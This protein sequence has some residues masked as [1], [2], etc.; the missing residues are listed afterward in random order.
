MIN[1]DASRFAR[2]SEVTPSSAANAGWRDF[3]PFTVICIAGLAVHILLIFL[4]LFIGADTLALLNVFSVAVWLAASLLSRKGKITCAALLALCEVM[5]HSTIACI[6]L[7]LGAGFQIYMWAPMVLSSTTPGVSPRFT[8]PMAVVPLLLLAALEMTLADVP[9]TFLHPEYL[10]YILLGNIFLTGTILLFTGISI[11]LENQRQ[12]QRLI[13]LANHDELTGLSNRRFGRMTLEHC[14]ELAERNKQPF[15]VAMADID[16]F[17]KLNDAFGHDAGDAVLRN[18]A[19]SFKS[20]LRKSDIVCRWGGE[21]F[22]ILISNSCLESAWHLLESL[23]ISIQDAKME[24]D[25]PLPGI[26]ISFGL[27]QFSPG[28][29][30][31]SL[32]TRADNLLYRAKAEGRNRT[33][34]ER[35]FSRETARD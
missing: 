35:D 16:Y 18:V 22:L 34:A 21:E 10:R 4:F 14:K 19:H 15:C 29:P 6:T 32:I 2:L 27:A 12:Q 25:Q 8:T 3:R 28:E 7:G 24:S 1:P 17:K 11:R 5:V 23:R 9:Y 13:E 20:R 31:G 26:T 30:V 33:V